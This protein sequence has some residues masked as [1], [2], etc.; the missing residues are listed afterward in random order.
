M[1]LFTFCTVWYTTLGKKSSAIKASKIESQFIAKTKSR[2][3]LRFARRLLHSEVCICSS[4]SVYCFSDLFV[5]QFCVLYFITLT[6]THYKFQSQIKFPESIF[7]DAG[8]VSLV[9]KYDCFDL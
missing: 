7:S 1:I 9:P 6:L 8:V 2:T 3:N 5:V 4:P